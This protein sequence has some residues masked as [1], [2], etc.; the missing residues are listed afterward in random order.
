MIDIKTIFECIGLL[1]CLS[2]ALVLQATSHLFQI[3]N[4]WGLLVCWGWV[5]RTLLRAVSIVTG[6]W[7]H[8][9]SSLAHQGLAVRNERLFPL[10]FDELQSVINTSNLTC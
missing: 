2:S 6:G 3:G 10:Y 1:G 8:F 7:W 4:I 5:R 9:K